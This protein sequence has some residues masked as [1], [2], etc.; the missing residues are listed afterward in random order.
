MNSRNPVEQSRVAG[1][2]ALENRLLAKRSAKAPATM[3]PRFARRAIAVGRTVHDLQAEGVR[4]FVTIVVPSRAYFACFV[5]VGAVEAALRRSSPAK[6]TLEPGTPVRFMQGNKYSKGTYLGQEELV[7]MGELRTYDNIRVGAT[8][9]LRVPSGFM[10]I[11]PDTTKTAKPDGG[12]AFRALPEWFAFSGS[13]FGQDL[14]ATLMAHTELVATLIGTKAAIEGELFEEEFSTFEHPGGRW[15]LDRLVF[16]RPVA[17]VNRLVEVIAASASP[18]QSTLART[19]IL[20]GVNA[21]V[22]WGAAPGPAAHVALLEPTSPAFTDAAMALSGVLRF[23]ERG[24]G[25]STRLSA[26]LEGLEWSAHEL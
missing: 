4:A 7:V 2:A 1:D 20:D 26:A 18:S 3:L 16:S 23:A 10:G 19:V 12:F 6:R 14:E 15:P 5:A 22:R 25:W 13:A 11:V 24:K 21:I 17:P 9:T 8:K